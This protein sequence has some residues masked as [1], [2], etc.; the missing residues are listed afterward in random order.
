MEQE[1]SNSSNQKILQKRK[2]HKKAPIEV[3]ENAILLKVFSFLDAK[4]VV[5]TEMVCQKW[6]DVIQESID[7]FPK[8]LMDQI[9][10]HFDEGEVL[11]YPI[12]EKKVPSRHIM[13]PVEKLSG[14]MKHITINSL[15]IRG[16]IPIETTP[17]LRSL[18]N[19][20]LELNQ[21]YFLWCD[22]D[23]YAETMLLDLF[24]INYE[25]LSDIGF[26]VCTPPTLI[27]D[28]LIMLNLPKLVSIRI[29]N[30]GAFGIYLI[31]DQTLLQLAE[32]FTNNKKAVL[33][34]LDLANTQVTVSGVSA[35]IEA[36]FRSPNGHL[37]KTNTIDSEGA[38]FG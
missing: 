4:S 1:D 14:H 5:M 32:Y 7:E 19:L 3:L 37:K 12:D 25:T 26:E 33:E 9:K 21:I 16:L 20:K 29:W 2:S 22:F 18:S 31:T 13:P 38:P 10:L 11:V 8:M 24:T 36:W 23:G 34:T 17:V 35:L 6:K 28:Q 15:F 27:S 30:N